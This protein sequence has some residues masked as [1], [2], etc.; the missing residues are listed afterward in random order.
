M[1]VTNMELERAGEALKELVK[2]EFPVVT[3]YAIISLVKRVAEALDVSSSAR[4][5][6][7]RRYGKPDPK[8]NDLP[9]IQPGDENWPKFNEEFGLLMTM[10]VELIVA[11]VSIPKETA[12]SPS[13]LVALEK[14]IKVT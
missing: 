10:E 14:F 12:L 7:I 13:V 4:D 6:L 5:G 8:N 9:A 2:K 1:K 11:P 3:S